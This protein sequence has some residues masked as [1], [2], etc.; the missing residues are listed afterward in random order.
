MLG[1]WIVVIMIIVLMISTML[2]FSV[3]SDSN[4]FCHCFIAKGHSLPQVRRAWDRIERPS[5]W[6]NPGWKWCRSVP[7]PGSD[8]VMSDLSLFEA[9]NLSQITWNHCS[10]PN[11]TAPTAVQDLGSLLSKTYK[12]IVLGGICKTCMPL[13]CLLLG[14][15]Q[16]LS[17]SLSTGLMKPE[18]T[19]GTRGGPSNA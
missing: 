17:L 15:L 1:E 3:L 13:T 9:G 18:E 7:C 6:R 12:L 10:F 2:F 11:L 16:S 4:G 8:W 14:K 19:W 5:C